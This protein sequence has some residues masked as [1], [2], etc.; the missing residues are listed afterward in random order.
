MGCASSKRIKVAIDVYRPPP[1]SFA[2]FD[3]NSIE[4]PW[5][6]SANNNNKVLLVYNLS[7]FKHKRV[8]VIN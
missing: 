2:V 8:G 5:L 1:T 6:K 3:I 7:T 4:E